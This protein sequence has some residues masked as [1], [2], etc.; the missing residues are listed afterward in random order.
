M[1]SLKLYGASHLFRDL[2]YDYRIKNY[3]IINGANYVYKDYDSYVRNLEIAS[4]NNNR[5]QSILSSGYSDIKKFQITWKKIRGMKVS[6]LSNEEV[7]KIFDKY[8]ETL[9]GLMAYLFTPLFAEK[10]LMEKIIDILRKRRGQIEIDLL[11]ETLTIPKKR[12]LLQE[13][14][15]EFLK[16]IHTWGS[17]PS[18]L[19]KRISKHLQ[20]WAWL[21]DHNYRGEFWTFRDLTSRIRSSKG[22][23]NK[24]VITEIR[25]AERIA[26][27][28]YN[29]L[30]KKLKFN[31]AEKKIID[32]ARGYVHF[33]TYRLDQ[34][35]Y[36]EF[37]VKNMLF[38]VAKR[39]ELDYKDLILLSPLEISS[40]LSITPN[41]STIIKKRRKSYAIVLDNY[42]L[43]IFSGLGSRLYSEGDG[44]HE[45]VGVIK[46]NIAYR[47]LVKG[48]ARVI[49]KKSDFNKFLPHDILVTSMTTPDFVPLM[50][51][52]SAIVTDEGGITCHAAIISRELKKPCI[53]GTKMATQILKDNDLI[54]VDANQGIVKILKRETK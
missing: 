31:P 16:I 40:S 10:I 14:N 45:K 6:S 17:K 25:R 26:E 48:R 21:G 42:R 41:L 3:K 32:L 33:R 8:I 47:G 27:T 19:T 52:C 22:I 4:K 35:F 50:K 46:G 20:S 11:I 38:E 43:K 53:I 7:K 24:K 23:N 5:L 1:D 29:N 30:L 49:L 9:L 36:S 44:I 54:E 13:E 15:I 34:L 2:G 51:A 28:V 39:L 18:D 12:S 37:L